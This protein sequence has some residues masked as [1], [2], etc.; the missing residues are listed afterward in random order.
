MSI[1]AHEPYFAWLYGQVENGSHTRKARRGHWSLLSQLHAKPF[2]WIVT[3]DENRNEDGKA[4]REEYLAEEHVRP[5]PDI[6]WM[7]PDASVLEVLIALSRRVSFNSYS[8]PAAWFW[9]LLENLEIDRVTDAHYTQHIAEE[10]DIV[11][12]HFLD[13]RYSA[14]GLGSI[15]PLRESHGNQRTTEMWYQMAAYLEEGEYVN[16]GP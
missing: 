16:N 4:L 6:P 2:R 15:F 13:R 12:D 7:G 9:K 1:F 11:L 10:I 3:N 5:D 14:D 8:T